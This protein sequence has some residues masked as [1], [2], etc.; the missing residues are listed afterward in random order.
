V[1]HCLRHYRED[2]DARYGFEHGGELVP[3]EFTP[4]CLLG[5]DARR[6]VPSLA[7]SVRP[8]LDRFDSPDAAIVGLAASEDRPGLID[9]AD[10]IEVSEFFRW[11]RL[12]AGL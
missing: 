5:L 11:F 12:S 10:R 4:A 7:L 1:F 8:S 3:F 6:F 2:D 9:D